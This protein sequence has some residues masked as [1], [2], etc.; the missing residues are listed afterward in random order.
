MEKPTELYYC[1][2]CDAYHVKNGCFGFTKFNIAEAEVPEKKPEV[3]TVFVTNKEG[4]KID[5]MNLGD[6]EDVVEFDQILMV[7]KRDKK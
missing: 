7:M 1:I 5:V 2:K 4:E 6:D 3:K